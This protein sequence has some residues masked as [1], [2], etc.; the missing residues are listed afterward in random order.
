MNN[1]DPSAVEWDVIREDFPILRQEVRGHPLIYLDS[2]ASSQKPRCVIEALR[3]YYEYDNANV[4]RGL[5]ELSSRATD[6]YEGAREKVARYIGAA[7]A[8][9]I[10]FTRGT[11]ESINLVANAWGG[12]FLKAGDVV[13]LTEMEHHSNIVPWQLLA[14]RTGIKVRYLP[15]REEGT[16]ELAELDK[17]LTPEVKI[18]AFTHISNSLGTINPVQE[19]CRAARKVGAISLVDAAQSAGHLPINVQEIGCDFLAFSGH[20]MCA[21][22]GIG[23]LYGRR[24]LLTAMPP[25][26]GG[27]EMISSV[28]FEGATFKDAPHKF[29]AGTPNI[30]GAIGLGAAIDYIEKIGRAEIFAHDEALVAYAIKRMAELPGIRIFGPSGKRGGLV[31]FMMDSAHPHDVTTFADRYGLALRGGH[32]CN[33]PLMRKF[34]LPG[35]TRASFYFYN[36][37]AEVDRMIEILKEVQR[38]FA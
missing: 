10:V 24:E 21:P 28:T 14:E 12:K 20:K 38:F 30:A 17:W 18:F 33:Q 22:T 5:H 7:S 9:E 11:T 16:L 8:E 3:H 19:L 36:N 15:V 6:A 13:L 25:W 35:T 4:H 27:G 1:A 23:A 31:S 37:R 2:A 32:H 29:E 34:R 26:H